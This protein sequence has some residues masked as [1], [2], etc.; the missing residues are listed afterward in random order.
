MGP[1][2]FTVKESYKTRLFQKQKEKENLFL[3]EEEMKAA[4]NNNNNNNN[5]SNSVNNKYNDINNAYNN[6]SNI[7]NNIKND[8]FIPPSSVLKNSK[9]VL[10]K[11][12]EYSNQQKIL[13]PGSSKSKNPQKKNHFRVGL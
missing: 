13:Q 9:F 5:V 11:N 2:F 4:N 6:S 8:E 1:M 7:K 12:S 10:E 3:M